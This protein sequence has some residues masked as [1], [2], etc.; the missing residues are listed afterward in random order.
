MRPSGDSV[1]EP[2]EYISQR[3][4]RREYH[5]RH[6]AER[7]R[8]RAL[9]A[10]HR[11]QR[12]VAAPDRARSRPAPDPRVQG[13][14]VH[15]HRHGARGHRQAL[16]HADPEHR[17][18]RLA[19][20][21]A[22]RRGRVRP[23]DLPD[24]RVARA[25]AGPPAALFRAIRRAHRRADPRRHGDRAPPDR[26]G[27]RRR[28]DR[29]RDRG[30][31]P[32]AAPGRAAD[33]KTPNMMDRS[34]AFRA[35][36]RRLSDEIVVATYSSAFEWLEIAPRPLNYFS[37]GAM[38]LDSSHALGLALGR[39]DKRVVVL[40]GDGSLLMNLG[41]LVTIAAVA[42]KN[43]IH[44]VAQNDTYEANGGHPIPSGADF[45]AMARA[46]GY[47]VA[48][49]FAELAAFEAALDTLLATQGPVFATLR[50][51]PS[52]PLEYDYQNIYDPAR[53]AAFAAAL[54]G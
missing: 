50:V 3:A 30:R 36:A 7:R 53:R 51:A 47:P 23:A 41:S 29:A 20:R 48:H 40:Q 46:A 13:G 15:R 49:D 14:R 17:A 12:R 43:L 19:Q 35:L 32:G 16:A 8:V 26:G 18:A 28:Q 9:G 24:G 4:A 45:A 33:R 31:I 22:R 5:R 2:A 10:R 54:K 37:V 25:R 27:R 44:F 52:G 21:V 6:Q 42:P 34:L 1:H 11:H 39:P 38:G